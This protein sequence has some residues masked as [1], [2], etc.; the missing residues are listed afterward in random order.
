MIGKSLANYEYTFRSDELRNCAKTFRVW[1]KVRSCRLVFARFERIVHGQGENSEAWRH[2]YANRLGLKRRRRR[3]RR[4]DDESRDRN[5]DGRTSSR[6]NNVFALARIIKCDPRGTS[7]ARGSFRKARRH[8]TGEEISRVLDRGSWNN[9]I[10]MALQRPSYS[11]F[12]TNR[13]HKA[14]PRRAVQH[15]TKRSL[16]RCSK[17]K[18]NNLTLTSFSVDEGIRLFEEFL[19]AQPP[20]TLCLFNQ[21][22]SLLYEYPSC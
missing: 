2:G 11:L 4:F 3:R 15:E 21:R 22:R 9:A 13:E 12:Q 10:S 17:G 14:L 1:N 18:W 5:D 20:M 6:D 8:S 7:G 19:D 16:K